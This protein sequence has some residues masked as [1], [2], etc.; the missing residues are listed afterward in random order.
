VIFKEL[1]PFSGQDKFQV[2]GRKA[3]EQMAHYLRRFF[4]TSQEVD[5]LNYLRVDLAGE[6]AQIDH[7]VLHPFGLSIVESKSVAGSVQI[8]DDGQWIR[9]YNKQPQG[10]RS[11]VTQAKMQGMLLRE[12]LQRTVNQ[13]GF[14]DSIRMDVLVAISDNGTIQWPASGALPEVC[15][16]DQIPERVM[17]LIEQERRGN[18]MAEVLTGSHRRAIVDFLCIVHK[19][20]KATP[21]IVAEPVLEDGWGRS[22]A[23]SGLTPQTSTVAASPAST[24]PKKICKHCGGADLEA[25]HGKF[26]YYFSCRACG[27]NTGIKFECPSCGEEGRVRKHGKDFFAECKSCDASAPYHT[28]P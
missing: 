13:K 5:V 14:F 28:N 26:G 19:P 16:A 23:K 27:K 18:Q 8:K 20:L 3:E 22:N 17:A 1:D 9:W 24:L 21:P 6:V 4:G 11:P 7:L 25:Q 10:M 15:K 12:L 2:A